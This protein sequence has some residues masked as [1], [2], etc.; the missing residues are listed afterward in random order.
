M[1][2]EPFVYGAQPG[3]RLW[4]GCVCRAIGKLKLARMAGVN[5]SVV[6]RVEASR[7]YPSVVTL[8]RLADALN[9]SADYL[10]GRVADERIPDSSPRKVDALER[11][12]GRLSHAHRRIVAH[13]VADLGEVDYRAGKQD[14]KIEWLQKQRA[15]G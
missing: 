4:S 11:D 2:D 7:G 6:C 13:L 10:L 5:P 15:A 1:S 12:I 14:A 9:V 3:Q 8:M